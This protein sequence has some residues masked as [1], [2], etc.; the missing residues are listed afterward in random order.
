MLDQLR[1]VRGIVAE[2]K[3]LTVLSHFHITPTGRVYGSNGKLT[4]SA[5]LDPFHDE[6]L[7]VPAV[8]FLRAVDTCDG[9]PQITIKDGKI[10]VRRGKFRA[11]IPL[12]QDPVFLPTPEGQKAALPG[13][14]LDKLQLLRPF[15]SDD[16]SRPWATAVLIRAGYAW[17]TN[18][19]SLARTKIDVDGEFVVPRAV[20]DELL[21]MRKPP[22][23]LQHGKH[24]LF[25]HCGEG[26]N[27]HAV[28]VQDRW[29]DVEPILLRGEEN[30]RP[31]TETG[32]ELLETVERLSPFCE[33]KRYPV[34]EF[35][36]GVIKTQDG[37]M[38]AEFDGVD[39]GQASFHYVTLK[40]V[41]QA[42]THIAIQDRVHRFKGHDIEGVFM[43]LQHA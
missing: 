27:L 8:P 23:S 26:V 10:L 20:I 18:N 16:A 32:V 1:L 2:G 43:G 15:V 12:S 42:A 21:R 17:A 3:V 24:G 40:I 33:D 6:P 35:H 9:E 41:L 29:P 25:L 30:P 5:P 19:V 31:W 14:F 13:D 38:S 39:L 4:L 37:S 28:T 7:T 11:R 36:S 22:R 34:V